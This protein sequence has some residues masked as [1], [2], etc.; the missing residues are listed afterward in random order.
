MLFKALLHSFSDELVKLAASMEDRVS[1]H[2][3]ADV[4]DWK[5]FEKNLRSSRFGAAIL[6]S[7]DSDEKLKKYVTNVGA[8]RRSTD[9]VG[10]IPSRTEGRVYSIKKLPNGR[11]GCGCKDWQYSHSWRG[12]DC[13]HIK[14]AKAGGLGV[15][16]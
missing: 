14:A 9:V 7:P 15:A 16:A 10:Q 5:G 2:H 4:K 3:S 13:T 12:T 1:K 8:Y 6:K 11:L